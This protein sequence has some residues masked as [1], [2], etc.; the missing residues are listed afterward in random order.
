V[1]AICVT[2]VGKRRLLF[3]DAAVNGRMRTVQILEVT[4]DETAS[5][6]NASFWLECERE[7]DFILRAITGVDVE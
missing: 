7:A 4:R 6:F 1:A 2:S 5:P 3:K